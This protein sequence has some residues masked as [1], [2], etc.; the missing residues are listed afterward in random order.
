[1][2][3]KKNR[4]IRRGMYV[5]YGGRIYKVVYIFFRT[6]V[7]SDGKLRLALK[8]PKLSYPVQNL[9]IVVPAKEDAL[10]FG[11]IK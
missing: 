4:L 2:F 1:M 7:L 3:D 6:I 5:R 11:E 10:S 9:E 8:T